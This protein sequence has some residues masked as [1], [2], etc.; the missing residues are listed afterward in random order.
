MHLLFMALSRRR[1]HL[2]DAQAVRMC[3]DPLALAKALASIAEKY[4]GAGEVEEGFS[5]L[6]IQS[7]EVS[8]LDEG[9]GIFSNLFSTHPP[10]GERVAR[11]LAFAKAD[12]SALAPAAAPSGGTDLAGQAAPETSTREE[13][14]FRVY[15]GE[16]RWEGPF[17]PRQ[18]LA[19]GLVDPGTW[20]CPEGTEE[21][22][23]ASA[24]PVLIPLFT[25]RVRGSVVPQRCPRCRG[26][27]GEA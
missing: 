4:R 27:S 10:V 15:R 3:K 13:P 8:S 9:R 14:W 25:D 17:T 2:A 19:A 24:F 20:V 23:P 7:P 5:V 12:V 1:E 11:L 21:V 16:G 6:F 26:A 22:K 18:M